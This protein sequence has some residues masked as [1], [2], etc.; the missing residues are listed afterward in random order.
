MTK[1]PL[2]SCQ[3]CVHY[4][5]NSPGDLLVCEVFPDGIPDS[6]L[7]G[8][9]DHRRTFPGD[10]GVLYE[11]MRSPEIISRVEE[12]IKIGSMNMDVNLGDDVIKRKGIDIMIRVNPIRDRFG[13]QYT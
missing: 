13:D 3:T 2:S 1:I 8:V 9:V 12:E 6:I 4:Y 5:Q 11:P 10:Q 7:S